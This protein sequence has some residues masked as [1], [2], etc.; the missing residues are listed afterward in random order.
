MHKYKLIFTYG[1]RVEGE[2]VLVAASHNLSVARANNGNR[3]AVT[4]NELVRK[5]G[6]TKRRIPTYT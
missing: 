5:K 6:E 2:Q 1:A 3:E 4:I